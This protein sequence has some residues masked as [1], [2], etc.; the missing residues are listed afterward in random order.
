[1]TDPIPLRYRCRMI[2]IVLG[3]LINV[4]T[5][6]Q[7]EVCLLPGETIGLTAEEMARLDGRWYEIIKILGPVTNL[8]GAIVWCMEPGNKHLWRR[9]AHMRKETNRA[10]RCAE[11]ATTLKERAVHGLI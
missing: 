10:V 2:E 4:G 5:E 8:E 1:M 9:P 11:H 3:L 6:L 7:K